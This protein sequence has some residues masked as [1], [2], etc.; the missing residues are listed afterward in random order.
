MAASEL[1]W[2]AGLLQRNVAAYGDEEVQ[3][4]V[5]ELEAALRFF[6]FLLENRRSKD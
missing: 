3:R 6:F 1:R 5:A 4:V 2:G